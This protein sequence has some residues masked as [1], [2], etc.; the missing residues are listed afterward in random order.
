MDTEEIQVKAL[1][2]LCEHVS[3]P[4]DTGN[5][6]SLSNVERLSCTLHISGS[7]SNLPLECLF[8]IY[9]V[10]SVGDLIVNFQN[11]FQGAALISKS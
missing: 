4:H 3:G 11:L 9:T 1:Y 8:I 6:K 7:F 10:L 5:L 2:S